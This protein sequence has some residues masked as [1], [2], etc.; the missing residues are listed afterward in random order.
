MT[1]AVGYSLLLTTILALC[2]QGCSPVNRGGS[3]GGGGGGGGGDDDDDDAT[4]GDDDDTTAGDDDDS[5]QPG[6]SSDDFEPNGSSSQAAFIAEGFA[7]SS[8]EGSFSAHACPEED[9]WF[10]FGVEAGV[11]LWLGVYFENAEGDIDIA[12]YASDGELLVESATTDDYEP[13][14]YEAW[15][16]EELHL[17]V[18]LYEDDGSTVGNEYAIDWLIE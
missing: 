15:L 5:T 4:A 9:D 6:C 16:D 11:T 14:M 10:A 13:L 2:S 17:R 18:Y 12:L 3:G 1:K 7:G 8:T